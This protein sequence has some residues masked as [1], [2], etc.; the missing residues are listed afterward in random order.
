MKL[1]LSRKIQRAPAVL[2]LATAALLLPTLAAGVAQAQ[3]GGGTAKPPPGAVA[4]FVEPTLGQP[5]A[6]A[7]PFTADVANIHG[8]DVTGFMQAATVDTGNS[9]CLHTPVPSIAT[10]PGN[11][12]GGT[13]RLNNVTVTVPCNLTIQ[14]PANTFT[15]ADFV[16]GGPNLAL[17]GT[18][19]PAP[20]F[21]IRAVGNIV[22]G[23][24][25]AAL[26][27]FSQQS[28]NAGQGYITAIDY[29]HGSFTVDTGLGNPPAR[30][31]LND[32]AISGLGGSTAGT[33]RQS[34][35]QSPD[36]R[37]SMDQNNP[38]VVSRTGY[39]MCVPRVAPATAV[40]GITTAETDP[41]CPQQNRPLAAGGCRNFSQA[42][43]VPP[44][45]GELSP[46]AA[47]QK[48][49]SQFVFKDPSLT[50]TPSFQVRAATDPDA[51]QQVPFEVG[52][53]V[54]FTGSLFTDTAGSYISAHTIEASVGL[55]TQPG[56]KP[57]YIHI[58]AV[59]IGTA[60]PLAVAVNGAA[61]ETQDRLVLEAETTDV[62]SPA[63]IYLTDISPSTGKVRN[64]WVTP[65]AMT[66]ENNGPNQAGT[67]TPIGGGI[68]TQSTGPAPQRIRL[69]ATKAPAGL[70]SNP[71]RTIR[72]TNRAT[73]VPNAPL[74]N[75]P[76][77]NAATPVDLCLN[78][79]A[80]NANGLQAG[81]YTAPIFNYIFPENI[82]GGDVIVPND[83]WH[84]G[85]LRFGEGANP[86]TPA[87][88]P[89]E[90]TP[91]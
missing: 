8:F 16:N 6:G 47:G 11:L 40:P 4:P 89:L 44:R 39:P 32:P 87:V 22:A 35:G 76:D 34:A 19:A 37:L 71:S 5:V 41:L 50:G 13:V 1:T 49:C 43:V 45:S 29:P 25:V 81:M 28:V 86:I 77:P 2:A 65:Q 62:Q 38:T 57:S 31:Q 90:P 80:T 63:D 59:S 12:M 79:L 46:P 20:S 36:P 84:L 9:A 70:L 91:W 51:R 68:T 48:Y 72:V 52:D 61:Q 54:L 21:E 75:N 10:A 26:M 67:L 83:F 7:Q 24:H 69:R 30:V 66:G 18:P 73:C 64:R 27:F 85:F 14:M 56:S 78:N 42:G 60:D 55:Y 33:G 23:N 17:T 15:W 3:G 82:R 88:G 74:G 53:F 58:G